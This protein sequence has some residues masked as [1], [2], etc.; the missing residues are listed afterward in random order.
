[1]KART[2]SATRAAAPSALR[3]STAVKSARGRADI[4]DIESKLNF[5]LDEVQSA[6]EPTGDM[7]RALASSLSAAVH[8]NPAAASA[9]PFGMGNLI[10]CLVSALADARAERDAARQPQIKAAGQHAPLPL[11]AVD[12]VGSRM[13][14]IESLASVLAMASESAGAHLSFDEICA[15]TETIG[16]AAREVRACI[17]AAWKGRTQ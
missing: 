10:A 16:T 15:V 9:L 8:A 5:L 11:E 12:L 4:N 17:D 7:L 6:D 13:R 3:A 14:R 1:M 2:S